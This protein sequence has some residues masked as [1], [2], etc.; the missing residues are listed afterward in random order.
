[1]NKFI[2][3]K[4]FCI[5][6]LNVLLWKLIIQ[7]SWY[8]ITKRQVMEQLSQPLFPTVIFLNYGFNVLGDF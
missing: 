7:N 8:K 4:F 6:T 3:I 2:L 5:E 1:M